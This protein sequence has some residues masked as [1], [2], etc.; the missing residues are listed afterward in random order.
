MS[1]CIRRKAG[2]LFGWVA[3]LL[4]M[5]ATGGLA[6]ADDRYEVELLKASSGF[7]GTMCWV[8]ARAGVIPGGDRLAVM[9]SQKLLLTGSDVFYAL[10]QFDS[11][12]GG[13]TWSEPRQIESFERQTFLGPDR[14]LPTGADIAPELL[15]AGDETTVCDFV[16]QWH[17]KA[18][19]LLGIGHT[20]WYRDNRVMSVRPRGTAYAVYDHA[21]A[22]WSPWKC[23]KLPAER[24]FVCA[25]SGSQQRVDLPNG[26]VLLP[27]YF[28]EPE[29][30][31][32]SS[33]VVRCRF[34]GETLTYLEHGSE[35]TLPVQR[36]LYEPSVTEFG[37]RWYLTLRNDDHGYVC[38]SD[39][40]LRYSEP[41]RWTFD[42]GEELG[43][44]NTQQHWVHGRNA[45]YLVYTRRAANY[46]NA[47]A[48]VIG[49]TDPSLLQPDVRNNNDHVFR[50]RAPL[51]MAEVNPQTLQIIRATEQVLVPERGA[52][53]GNFGVTQ[54]SPDE[55][56]VTVTEWMQPEGVEQYGSD[57][58]IWVAKIRWKPDP[59]PNSL[60]RAV[61]EDVGMDSG[62]LN[63]I[64]DI[65]L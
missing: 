29:A 46:R 56:W 26:D 58:T 13:R 9:T 51:F 28:K 63:V 22:A 36:G 62:R 57:N 50:H 15:Q 48:N 11:A 6:Q 41:I 54:V 38:S 23:L 2:C 43:N 19:K 12:D 42:D 27:I 31:Q 47:P 32:Y 17:Q 7:D 52:R 21:A 49:T 25:G 5:A 59:T 35:H 1:E 44:Y 20:V 39:D 65:V 55:A 10:H 61:P 8:H 33:T 4:L 45:L 30:R 60:P 53:L 40:G 18:Q 24:K 3:V 16:P 34:D 14:P 64:D 37:G